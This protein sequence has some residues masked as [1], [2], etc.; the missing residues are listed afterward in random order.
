[1]SGGLAQNAVVKKDPE[2]HY[3]WFSIADN[4]VKHLEPPSGQYDLF[5]TQYTTLLFT[6]EG[7]PYPYLLPGVLSNRSGISVALDT[8]D[9]FQDINRDIALTQQYSQ[10]MDAIGWDWKYYD[11]NSS[12][13]TIRPNFNYIIRNKSGYFYKLRFIGFYD[14]NGSKGYPV[15]EYQGL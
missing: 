14:Q 9:L 15:I 8:V 13:Y 11:F 2:V 10:S 3:L 5:F 7:I 12:V 1:L 4:A 6:D